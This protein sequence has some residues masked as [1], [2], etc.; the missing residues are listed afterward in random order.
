MYTWVGISPWISQV[1]EYIGYDT[2]GSLK[3]KSSSYQNIDSQMK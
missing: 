3:A 1:N 2:Y